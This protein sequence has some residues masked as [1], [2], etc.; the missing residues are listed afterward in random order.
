MKK[1][2]FLLTLLN[3]FSGAVFA[4]IG[5][6]NDG[7]QPDPSAGLDV[8]FTDKGFLM[9]RLTTEQIQAI[10]APANGL[11]VYCTSD[12]KVYI[13]VGPEN[14]WKE[15]A[16]GTGSINLPFNACGDNL[17]VNHLVTNGVAPVDKTVTYGTVTGIPGE[18]TKCW[19]TSNLGSD[20]QANAVDDATE[21]SAGWY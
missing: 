10:P 4:Q 7:S 3:I 17:T 16:Y 15:L 5:F 20:H 12:G 2:F 1:L 11:Q 8:N 19:I 14:K 21:E 13:F 6:N 18:P 9:P